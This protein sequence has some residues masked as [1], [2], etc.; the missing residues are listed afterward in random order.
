MFEI[1]Y[2]SH[3]MPGSRI[4]GREYFVCF[5]NTFNFSS[6]LSTY[7]I[8]IEYLAIIMEYNEF[9]TRD[10]SNPAVT[11]IFDRVRYI[12]ITFRMLSHIDLYPYLQQL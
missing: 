11:L 9:S 4:E 2:S 12:V 8:G 5:S 3:E 7:F 1:R 10:M 6:L